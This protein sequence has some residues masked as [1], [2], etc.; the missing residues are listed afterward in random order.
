MQG[1]EDGWNQVKRTKTSH[2]AQKP[3]GPSGKGPHQASSQ[4]NQS[5]PAPENKFE[6]LSSLQENTQEGE[7]QK[8]A[9]P[10]KETLSVSSKDASVA[11]SSKGTPVG[12]EE[13]DL[14]SE[15]SEEEGEIGDSQTSVRRSTRGRK[16]DREK[17]EQET[18][19]DKL[20][21]S[22]PTLEKLLAKKT[23][24]VRSQPPGSK[25]AQQNKGK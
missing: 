12:V 1:K 9:S 20:Q 14:E 16:T 25:G 19:K 3:R 15:D 22:Q 21:G 4:Q 10:V 23:K 17:R 8:T 5:K 24:M 2:K 6:L 18:Y 7:A 13:E 11:E